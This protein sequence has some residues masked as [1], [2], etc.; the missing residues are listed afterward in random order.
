MSCV[1]YPGAQKVHMPYGD[2]RLP[3][4][5]LD[6]TPALPWKINIIHKDIEDNN[7]VS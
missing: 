7:Y 4:T 2:P 1:T 6:A 5:S 3:I